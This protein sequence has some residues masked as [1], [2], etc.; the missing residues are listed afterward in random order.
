MTIRFLRLWSIINLS[1][2][3]IVR[4][5]SQIFNGILTPQTKLSSYDYHLLESASL[6]Y[7][8][9]MSAW[10]EIETSNL[11]PLLSKQIGNQ[12]LELFSWSVERNITQNEGPSECTFILNRSNLESEWRENGCMLPLDPAVLHSVHYFGSNF[13]RNQQNDYLLFYIFSE[14]R[15]IVSPSVCLDQ[16]GH[17]QLN[18]SSHLLKAVK[19]HMWKSWGWQ[20]EQL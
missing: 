1:V 6:S 15:P 7:T 3:C 19:S 9:D 8:E 5:S 16:E 18:T 12:S 14:L 10:D 2:Y 4:K 13:R 20:H 17:L 11:P